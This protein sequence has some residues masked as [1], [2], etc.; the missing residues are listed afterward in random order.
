MRTVA[1]IV[2]LLVAGHLSF[3][4]ANAQ[5]SE[6][7]L[8]DYAAVKRFMAEAYANLDWAVGTRKM[9]LM[10]LDKKTL[11]SL[12]AATSD[13]EARS[14]LNKFLAAFGDG[15]LKLV[16]V[17]DAK[18][19]ER[20]LASISPDA[21]G[22]K[23]CST[24]GYK[25][26]FHRFSLPF[27]KAPG[28]RQISS[29]SDQF[30]LAVFTLANGKKYGVLR[31]GL[32]SPD[33]YIGNC[34]QTWNEFRLDL[35]AGCD[36][37]CSIRFSRAVED[38]LTA[39]LIEQVN[40]L[41]KENIDS[42]IVDIGGNGG[43]TNWVE[44]AA[45]VLSPKPLS[46]VRSGFIRHPH[47]GAILKGDLDLIIQDLERTDLTTAQ[48]AYLKSAASTLQQLIAE[49]KTPCD[50]GFV[51]TN[52]KPATPCSGLLM[53]ADFTDGASKHFRQSEIQRL[54][55]RYLFLD[56]DL[57]YLE[58]QVKSKLIVLVDAKTASASENFASLMQYSGAAEVVGELT[59]GAGC[60]YVDGGTNYVL[61][62]S[63]LRL[64][65]PDCVR[66]RADGINEVNGI[67]PDA[68]IW[69]RDDDKDKRLTKLH[70]YLLGS[71]AEK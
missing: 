28:Y 64:R 34:M 29:S 21:A 62:N 39:K 23:V 49:T 18:E 11:D 36:R 63:R 14:I 52:A 2:V 13:G 56:P 35:K 25:F 51:W 32:F 31:I 17:G 65:M 55:S 45:R 16:E 44:T 53:K 19:N 48:K 33:G 43:G 59:Y 38:R 40:T 8:Q 37:D 58:S 4:S 41:H 9:D 12:R 61:P 27:D 71:K 54:R 67:Q 26:R 57:K 68:P 50:R 22:D 70:G 6:K 15:H 3:Q 10:A 30:P 20:E 60:G 7:W 1:R 5:Q 47:W 42:L 24:L 69:G 66:Y 46:R